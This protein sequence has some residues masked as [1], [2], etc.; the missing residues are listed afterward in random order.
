MPV[1]ILT[2]VIIALTGG[3]IGCLLGGQTSRSMEKDTERHAWDRGNR[4]G[5]RLDSEG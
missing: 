1:G 2:D 4:N 3:I 5:N